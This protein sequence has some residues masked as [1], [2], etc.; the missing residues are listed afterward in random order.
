MQMALAQVHDG[1]TGEKMRNWMKKVFLNSSVLACVQESS[2]VL[3]GIQPTVVS[4]TFCGHPCN[5]KHILIQLS[6]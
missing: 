2:F 5:H 1:G 3:F 4:S 6:P